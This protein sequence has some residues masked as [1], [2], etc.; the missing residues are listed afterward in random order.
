M[1]KFWSF[2]V[3]IWENYPFFDILAAHPHQPS[4]Q[5]DPLRISVVYVYV[6]LFLYHHSD[7]HVIQLSDAR[8]AAEASKH[9]Y[10]RSA[11]VGSTVPNSGGFVVERLVEPHKFKAYVAKKGNTRLIV[12]RGTDG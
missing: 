10:S 4:N 2:S 11:R 1:L 5:V 12:F 6:P 9:I 3:G 8:I 7:G